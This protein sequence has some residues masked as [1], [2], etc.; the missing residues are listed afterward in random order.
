MGLSRFCDVGWEPDLDFMPKIPTRWVGPEALEGWFHRP[1]SDCFMFG[2]TV[3]EIVSGGLLPYDFF[4]GNAEVAEFVLAGKRLDIVGATSRFDDSAVLAPLAHIVQQCWL[5][6]AEN[7][8][9]FDVVL[10]E[11]KRIAR[12]ADFT[13]VQT[14]KLG[15]ADASSVGAAYIHRDA[16]GYEDAYEKRRRDQVP[17]YEHQRTTVGQPFDANGGYEHELAVAR[18]DRVD[19][20]EPSSPYEH[21]QTVGEDGPYEH[22][23]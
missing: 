2:V 20:D 23:V 1:G 21:E 13:G 18:G 3:F 14:S 19:D 16:N 9:N 7:R 12:D 4:L 10:K 17:Q 8:P 15:G 5:Q 6:R 11:C 22:E